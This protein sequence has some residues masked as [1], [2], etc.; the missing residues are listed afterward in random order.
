MTRA[1]SS[2]TAGAMTQSLTRSSPSTMQLVFVEATVFLKALS[3]SKSSHK[4]LRKWMSLDPV[5]PVVAIGA[6]L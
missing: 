3:A 1:A 6:V 2:L 5:L 4:T